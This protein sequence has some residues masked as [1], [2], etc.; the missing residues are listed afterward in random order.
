MEPE[1]KIGQEIWN[2]CP[3]TLDICKAI[4]I[5]YRETGRGHLYDL[6][7]VG[8]DYIIYGSKMYSKKS[9]AIKHAVKLIKERILVHKKF[10]KK[11]EKKLTD[12]D[13]E[14]GDK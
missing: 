5:R 8:A 2:V 3:I 10:I 9:D 6:K 11:F 12:I 1:F 7:P 13:L 14:S 4:V